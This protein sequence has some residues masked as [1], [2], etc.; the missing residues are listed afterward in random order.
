MTINI[1][2]FQV[3]AYLTQPGAS[4]ASWVGLYR[5]HMIR[6][7]PTSSW[8]HLYW[9]SNG[10]QRHMIG[11]KFG[12]F[13]Q[14]Q[15]FVECRMAKLFSES[16]GWFLIYGPINFSSEQ[17]SR[18]MFC[19]SS[20]S[21]ELDVW[22]EEQVLHPDRQQCHQEWQQV[23]CDETPRPGC[24]ISTWHEWARVMTGMVWIHACGM[25]FYTA[26]SWN[27]PC[28][29]WRCGLHCV[30]CNFKTWYLRCVSMRLP[31]NGWVI[32]SSCPCLSFLTLLWGESVRCAWF[33]YCILP[34]IFQ[35]S[36]PQPDC[37]CS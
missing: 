12:K 8:S 24:M 22:R 1:I 26:L 18:E 29:R 23:T 3:R 10:R 28:V 14:V 36:F 25:R 19:M 33:L 4:Q 13:H 9:W 35:C 11:R 37:C 34:D 20:H 6:F 15:N 21:H 32:Y 2:S 17:F 31:F 30:C 16:I 5:Y 27:R 7:H